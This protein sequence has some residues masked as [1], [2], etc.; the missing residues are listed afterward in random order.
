MNDVLFNRTNSPELV[1]KTAVFKGEREALFAGYLIR[2]NQIDSIV[3]ADYLNFYLNSVFAR[4]YG[5]KVK[6]DG[7][8]QSNING[9]KLVAYPFPYCCMDEQRA[10][11]SEVESRFSVLEVLDRAIDEGLRQ[12]ET[13]SQSILKKAFEGRLLNEAELAAV[14]ND[15]E[16]EP[17]DKLLKRIQA[18]RGEDMQPS[19]TRRTRITTRRKTVRRYGEDITQNQTDEGWLYIA[20][21]I[22]VFS[23][24][25]A[26]RAMGEQA[27]A[28][29]VTKA[30]GMAAD[31]CKLEPDAIHHS[32]HGSQYTSY[33]F[34]RA[35][36][37]AG[38][39][40]SMGTTG[41]AYDNALA[42][43]FWASLQTE[44]LDRR[45]WKTRA[46]LRSAVFH[47]I[48]GFYNRKRLHSALDY[49]SPLE[50]EEEWR[51]KQRQEEPC[52]A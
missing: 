37:E 12:A 22:D 15:P 24:R 9:T 17:A 3:D 49:T 42:E 47:Y 16:Y 23:R 41:D 44:L 26:G 27:T 30:L 34:G 46:E 6:T 25:V 1:G 8:N 38:I 39:L 7:V 20:A 2:I 21:V 50:F 45:K 40:P 5:S 32:D 43:S 48:E 4:Q 36:R 18:K 52:V 51:K 31:N 35:L 14:R 28:E 13:L 33:M 19:R 10:I 29:L 11:V